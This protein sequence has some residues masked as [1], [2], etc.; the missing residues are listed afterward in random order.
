M[1]PAFLRHLVEHS[2][3]QENAATIASSG[4]AGQL[5]SQWRNP[6]DILSLLLIIEPE[7]IQRA[8]AQLCGGRI[9]P[10]SLS[11]GWVAYSLRA[12]MAVLGGQQQIALDVI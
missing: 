10:V 6:S 11:F 12:L 4:L 9:S 2:I 5:R 8:L 3:T 7:V 1:P